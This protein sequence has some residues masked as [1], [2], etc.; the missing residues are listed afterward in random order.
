MDK[1][2]IKVEGSKIPEKVFEGDSQFDED[3]QMFDL[4]DDAMDYIASFSPSYPAPND[5]PDVHDTEDKV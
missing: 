4:V 1:L 3:S 2:W 5:P